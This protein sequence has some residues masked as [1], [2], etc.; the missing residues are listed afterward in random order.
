M[1]PIA[2]SEIYNRK[3]RNQRLSL[4]E[5]R[6]KAVVLKSRPSKI[7]LELTQNCNFKCKMCPQSFVPKYQRYSSALNM[8]MQLFEK[9]ASSLFDDA[10]FVDLRGFGETVILPYW[11]ELV[12]GL[13]AHPLI[14]WHLVTNLSLPRDATW[15]KMIKNGFILGFSCDA[16]TKETFER[17]RVRSHFDKIVHNLGVVSD[18]IKKYKKGFIYFIVTVQKMNIAELPQILELARR[19]SV[20][21][22]QFKI[23][24]RNPGH[25]EH[26]SDSDRPVLLA[27]VQRSL[28]LA[29]DYGIRLTIN[30]REMLDGL[31]AEKVRR[32][33]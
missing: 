1:S 9:V 31:D 12:D 18:S 24:Q 13:D 4:E 14:N 23:V 10:Y 22:V 30:D 7:L 27:S 20:K 16:G 28:E 21:E 32:A 19:F 2:A 25:E 6:D 29:I 33:D 15:E 8:P 3:V 5:F 11:P 26:L 17:I